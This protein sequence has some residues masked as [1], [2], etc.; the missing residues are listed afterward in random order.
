[1]RLKAKCYRTN[2]AHDA[3]GSVSYGV[4]VSVIDSHETFSLIWFSQVQ[5]TPAMNVSET[6]HRTISNA[7]SA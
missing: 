3:V 4:K 1:M 2:W 5:E 7:L 6:T